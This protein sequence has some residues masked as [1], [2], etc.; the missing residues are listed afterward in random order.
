MLLGNNCSHFVKIVFAYTN[1]LTEDADQ[2]YNWN[3][4]IS[5]A[6]RKSGAAMLEIR[7]RMN[8]QTEE[9]WVEWAKGRLRSQKG[10]G[11]QLSFKEFKRALNIR[12]VR[13]HSGAYYM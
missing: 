2:R 5:D 12:K 10:E 7:D 3:T 4:M 1:R 9:Q 13:Y 6:R 11:K 8:E